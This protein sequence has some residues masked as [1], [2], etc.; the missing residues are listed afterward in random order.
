MKKLLLILTFIFVGCF[1]PE[2]LQL[3]KWFEIQ[4][5][6]HGSYE[7]IGYGKAK[8]LSEAKFKA[9]VD[10]AKQILVKIE[11]KSNLNLY[12]ENINS[13]ETYS[14]KYYQNSSEVV[15][16]I[17]LD[18]IEIIK[19]ELFNEKY[20]V[21]MKYDNL[22]LSKKVAKKANCKKLQTNS[23]LSKTSF[24]KKLKDELGC[25]P[26]Y[27]LIYKNKNWYVS[28]EENLFLIKKY[29]FIE[30]FVSKTSEDLNIEFLKD[31]K[32]TKEFKDGDIFDMKINSN[33]KGYVTLFNIYEDGRVNLMFAN[34]II[35][36]RGFS[37]PNLKA[38]ILN[39]KD[40]L[41]FYVLIFSKDKLENLNCFRNST[42]IL[43][44]QTINYNFDKFVKL[45]D[46]ELNYITTFTFTTK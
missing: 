32:I 7:I 42:E 16:E 36:K 39:D 33:Q 25:I 2:T 29:E 38:N 31:S 24:S 45:F 23:Y 5:I 40:T 12:H 18:G 15:K 41:D 37:I 27:N 35:D 26:K 3:P 9:R 43:N 19:K 6:S 11:S 4:N 17:A 46:R 28:Y 30:F 1:N 21:A 34:E 14:Q 20:Y 44:T 10:I 22:P 8:T 13:K